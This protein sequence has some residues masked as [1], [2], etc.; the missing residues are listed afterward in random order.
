MGWVVLG[1][2]EEP[3]LL[4]LLFVLLYFETEV[5]H[6]HCAD[7]VAG[8]AVFLFTGFRHVR[9]FFGPVEMF[10][11]IGIVSEKSVDLFIP[12]LDLTFCFFGLH[13]LLF[14]F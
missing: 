4:F 11:L 2:G 7:G 3:L 12:F 14:D 1:M 8:A 13:S 6:A 5:K 10:L 9:Y